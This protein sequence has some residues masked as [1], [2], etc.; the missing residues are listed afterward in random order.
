MDVVDV[1]HKISFTCIL[2]C[3]WL[4][5]LTPGGEGPETPATLL[6]FPPYINR[7]ELWPGLEHSSAGVG[8]CSSVMRMCCWSRVRWM[9]QSAFKR[10]RKKLVSIRCIAVHVFL[11]TKDFTNLLWSKHVVMGECS[12]II[13]QCDG[14][15]LK[16]T[17]WKSE[18]L[19]SNNLL[20]AASVLFLL[21]PL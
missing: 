1:V 17:A 3:C 6:S 4:M 11:H 12:W 14:T 19:F 8:E 18:L 9:W 20:L 16:I 7:R 10:C 5:F 13:N 15:L 2:S 21:K